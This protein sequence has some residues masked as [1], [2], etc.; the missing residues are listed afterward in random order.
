MNENIE[1]TV[2]IGIF[3]YQSED[4]K[5][6]RNRIALLTSLT[7]FYFNFCCKNEFSF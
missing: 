2:E 7:L 1:A 4:K 6:L 5:K 3:Q